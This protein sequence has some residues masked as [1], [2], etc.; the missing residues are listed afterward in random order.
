[1]SSKGM[2]KTKRVRI[3]CSTAT[4]SGIGANPK[5]FFRV[6][7]ARSCTQATLRSFA[8]LR[9]HFANGPMPRRRLACKRYS[10]RNFFE[11]PFRGITLDK[12]V[13]N[14]NIVVGQLLSRTQFLRLHR[15][16]SS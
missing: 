2:D 13:T 4:E 14:P 1:M 10:Q 16:S 11:S 3:R 5:T 7:D 9:S 8:P 15:L 6:S 12:Q